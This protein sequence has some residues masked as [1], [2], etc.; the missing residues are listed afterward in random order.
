MA[1]TLTLTLSAVSTADQNIDITGAGEIITFKDSRYTNK[2]S[3]IGD[4]IA[5]QVKLLHDAIYYDYN[6]G[7]YTM[8]YTATEVIITHVDNDHFDGLTKTA[9]NIS[10]GTAT[11]PQEATITV[12]EV[13]G[14]ATSPS[15]DEIEMDLT[16]TVSTAQNIE[17]LTITRLRNGVV[18]TIYTNATFNSTTLTIDVD[19]ES[20]AYTRA[21]CVLN[22]YTTVLELTPPQRILAIESVVVSEGPFTSTV[23]ITTNIFTGSGSN[24]YAV[25][26]GGATPVYQNIN[27]IPGLIPGNWTAHVKDVYGC[28]K[29]SAF[30]VEGGGNKILDNDIFISSKNSI[31]QANRLVPSG[32]SA[33]IRNWLSYDIPHLVTNCNFKWVFSDQQVA[34]QQFKSNY[35]LHTVKVVDPLETDPDATIGGITV[36]QMT[37]NINRDN[38]LEGK[39]KQDT[40]S[41]AVLVYFEPGNVYDENGNVIGTH[42]YD[43]VLP[44]YYEG[45][46]F[47]RIDGYDGQILETFTDTGIVYARTNIVGLPASSSTI[48]HTIHEALDYEVYE[49]DVD[50]SGYLNQDIQLRTRA[51]RTSTTS[52]PAEEYLSEQV[53]VIAHADLIAG[54]Y[55]ICQFWSNSSDREIDYTAKEVTPDTPSDPTTVPIKHLKNLPF[56][57]APRWVP[58]SEIETEKLD[59][60]M[61]KLDSKTIEVWELDIKAMPNIVARGVAKLFDESEY[62][63]IDGLLATTIT[64]VSAEGE[65]QNSK[66]KVQIAVVGGS[67]EYNTVNKSI[68]EF[69]PVVV[70]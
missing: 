32:K 1:Q 18:E 6:K 42:D 46:V 54:K 15:C 53:T 45:G 63:E 56:D 52:N 61:V 48:I 33:N 26:Q 34:K 3:S 24:Q 43:D 17:E 69:Y 38:Y 68:K 13:Y 62:I 35:P 23:T 37:D 40:E 67:N 16:F 12:A 19:R 47:I 20:Y 57:K 27:S 65:Y 9:T 60:A 29:E 8:S 39:I 66:L 36:N 7:Q 14:P 31:P 22:T 28:E 59:N 50:F 21:T 70:G 11:S 25:T 5:D 30:T 55:H 58:N 4:T 10:T 51:F 41:F 44:P 2:Q 49:Y 64:A